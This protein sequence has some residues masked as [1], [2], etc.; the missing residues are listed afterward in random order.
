ME[1]QQDNTA[2]I[3]NLLVGHGTF[4]ATKH[5]EQRYYAITKDLIKPGKMVVTKVH[6]SDMAADLLTKPV[7]KFE[8]QK[9]VERM[10]GVSRAASA[11][12]V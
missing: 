2:T 9:G 5:I 8:F 6:T 4:K 10:I 11:E 12:R 1:L 3:R 7:I